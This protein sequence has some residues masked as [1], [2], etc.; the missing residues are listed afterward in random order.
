MVKWSP[1][2]DVSVSSFTIDKWIKIR[3]ACDYFCGLTSSA[4]CL[5]FAK[6]R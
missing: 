4:N 6:D 3:A 1:A 5:I 2:S